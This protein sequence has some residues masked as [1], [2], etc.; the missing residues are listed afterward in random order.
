LRTIVEKSVTGKAWIENERANNKEQIANSD[1]DI[2]SN[3]LASR[4]IT[5]PEDIRLFLT[6]SIKEQMPDP[7]VLTDMD[8][9]VAIMADAIMQNKKIAI[10]G[11][12][13]VDGVTSTAILVKYLRGVGADPMWHLPSRGPE[14]YG[15]N[16]ESIEEF[17]AAGAS[18]LITVDCGIS[19]AREVA[20]AKELGMAVII[21]DH[22][23]PDAALPAADAVVNPKR[24]DDT[25]GLTYLA[26]VGVAYLFLVALNRALRDRGFFTSDRTEPKI[27]DYLDMVTLGTVCDTMP[28]IGLNRAFV[29]TGLKVLDRRQNLG[30][31]TLMSVAGAK[32]ANVYVA[33][34]VIGPRLNACG[35][36]DSANP[37]LEL[38]L[39]D[40]AGTA[41]FL[42]AQLNDMNKER[43]DIEQAILIRA[44]ELAGAAQRAGR[45]CLFIVGENWHGGV[46]GIIAGRLKDRFNMPT[47]VATKSDVLINGSGRSTSMVDLGRIIHDALSAGVLTEGGG[48]A[49]A[50]GFSLDVAKQDEFAAFLESAV[51]DQMEGTAPRMEIAIDAEIDAGGANLKM[52][53]EMAALAPFGQGNPEPTLLLNGGELAYATIMGTGHLRGSVRTSNGNLAFVGF[54]MAS[55]PVGKFLLDEANIGR[56]IKMCGKLK[57]NEY[58]GR[59]SAQFVVEDV[60]I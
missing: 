36:L 56:K 57:E 30:L 33:G 55:T 12:Y 24:A 41:G 22:H 42:A 35:R 13:D 1:N 17:A 49:A 27:I 58:N 7:F 60:A 21:T 38:L 50:A 25:S 52:V 3:V 11:D 10:F 4:G 26:G 37:A 32:S 34:F 16:T 47:C 40:N 29:S 31:R 54:N 23:S 5:D 18:V 20:R 14:G 8:R 46:M 19:G 43:K 45:R 2:V 39:T 15:L 48:H 59:V 44:L 28:L 53:R 6:P 51:I 9:A